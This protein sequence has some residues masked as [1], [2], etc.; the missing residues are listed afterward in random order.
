MANIDSILSE[1]SKSMSDKCCYR[2]FKFI[3]NEE[4]YISMKKNVNKNLHECQK[5]IIEISKKVDIVRKLLIY[6][7]K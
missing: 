1:L 5:K 4:N 6:Y 3:L 7:Q 2:N